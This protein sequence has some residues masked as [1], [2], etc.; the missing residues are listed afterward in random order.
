MIHLI[1]AVGEN[2]VIGK[3]NKIPWEIPADLQYFKRLTI[4]HTIVMGRKTFESIGCVLPGRE[5]IIVSST[6]ETLQDAVIVPT[7]QMALQIAHH[8]EIFIIGGAQ[9][10]QEA[11]PI[12]D[13]LNLTQ[14]HFMPD[15]DTYFPEIDW[16]QYEEIFRQEYDGSVDH[17]PNCTFLTYRKFKRDRNRS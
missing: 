11:L 15:G 16:K 8:E 9:L 1:A 17:V 6:L 13:E 14:V 3:E 7:L 10:Y 4:G 12:A 2:G 5:N